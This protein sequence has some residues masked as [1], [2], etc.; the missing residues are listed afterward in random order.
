MAINHISSDQFESEVIASDKPVI[1]DFFATW[2]G[3]CKMLSPVLEKFA[4]KHTEVKVVKVDV[5]DN[6]DLAAEYGVQGVPTLLYFKDGKLANQAVGFR[7]EGG[8]EDLIK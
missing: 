3:P 7:N 6:N 8:L 1:V 4:E 2:C 5:D